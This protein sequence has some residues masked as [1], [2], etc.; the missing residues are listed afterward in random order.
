[1]RS[2]TRP[3][4]L[5]LL[6]G[7]AVLGL[8]VAACGGTPA[9]TP[10]PVPTATPVPTPA[11]TPVPTTNGSGPD[12]SGAAGAIDQLD[13]FQ[14]DISVSGLLSGGSDSLV[15]M[16]AI[17][18]R[19]AEA[20]QFKLAGME[21]MPGAGGGLSVILIGS[22]A[23]VDLGTG[24]WIKQPGGAAMFGASF[25]ALSPER[26]VGSVP[27]GAFSLLPRVGQEQK[28]GVATT[29]YQVDASR[30]PEMAAEL[31]GD[32]RA[33]FWIADDGGYLVSMSLSG[34]T[35]VDGTETPITMSID[36][37]RFNDPTIEIVAPD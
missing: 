24:S 30:S 10:S 34:V 27:A 26:L 37:S 4:R 15:T 36:L 29:R 14:M 21:G 16:Q 11:A 33:D 8:L 1:M 18:D 9:P 12:L 3:P 6:A 32:A 25:E 17:V 23:W 13:A 7:V 35:D 19:G 22:D 5:R 31:G 20:I 28:N 2:T